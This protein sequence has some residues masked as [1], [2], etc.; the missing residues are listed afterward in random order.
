M[1]VVWLIESHV[2]VS[3]L[4]DVRLEDLEVV[5]GQL[6]VTKFNAIS[7]FSLRIGWYWDGI[8]KKR[9]VCEVPL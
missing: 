3:M 2:T 7:P 1:S 4:V 5:V 9:H 8:M 6:N